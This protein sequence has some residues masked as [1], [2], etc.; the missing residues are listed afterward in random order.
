MEQLLF[1]KGS[2]MSSIEEIRT[3][4]VNVRFEIKIMCVKDIKHPEGTAV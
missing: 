3:H 2:K 4:I 1:N